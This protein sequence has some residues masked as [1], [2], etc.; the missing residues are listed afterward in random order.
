MHEGDQDGETGKKKRKA[1]RQKIP[2]V[3]DTYEEY[4]KRPVKDVSEMTIGEL[5]QD[6]D[7]SGYIPSRSW[8]EDQ[9]AKRRASETGETE[10]VAESV[11]SRQAK[12]ETGETAAANGEVR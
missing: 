3:P 9:I 12:S 2:A 4:F 6:R 10:S 7:I 1:G 8:W 11:A 5:V